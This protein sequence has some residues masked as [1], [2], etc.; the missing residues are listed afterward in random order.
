MHID[1]DGPWYYIILLGISFL[2]LFG[3]AD[4][5][6]LI[7][8]RREPGRKLAHIGTG[9]L[10]L[11]FP[12]VFEQSWPVYLMCG[13]FVVMLVI[14]QR[15]GFW[16]GIN[17]VERVTYGSVAFPLAV[18]A[19]WYVSR[20]VDLPSLYALPLGVLTLADPAAAAI[21]QNWPIR[22]FKVF[23]AT[24]SLGGTVAFYMVALLTSSILVWL[25]LAPRASWPVVLTLASVTCLAEVLSQRGWDNWWISITGAGVM[26]VAQQSGLV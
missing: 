21:G 16:Q 5:V 18:A 1:W 6:R 3:L 13:V 23:G 9:L 4:V 12:L 11:T 14:S 7:T 2:A 19:L 24:R 22:E 25:G 8:K 20:R 15:R 10:A 26:L 17:G